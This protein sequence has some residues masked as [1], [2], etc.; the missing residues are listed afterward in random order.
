[1]INMKYPKL[2]YSCDDLKNNTMKALLRRL[3]GAHLP[4]NV[5]NH[6][7]SNL[8]R[9]KKLAEDYQITGRVAITNTGIEIIK[10]SRGSD[11]GTKIC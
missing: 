9:A 6:Y 5:F 8:E 3:S 1:M 11:S 2:K 10:G 7:K 4:E